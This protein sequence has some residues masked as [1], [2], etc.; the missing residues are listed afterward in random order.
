[1]WGSNFIS[2]HLISSH[3]ISSHLIS[4]HPV[5]LILKAASK[6]GEEAGIQTSME[7]ELE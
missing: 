7:D 2:S 6:A 4:S 5:Y 3:L 1:V